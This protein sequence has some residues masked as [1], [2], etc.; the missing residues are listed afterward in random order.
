MGIILACIYMFV[1][2]NI[3]SYKMFKTNINPIFVFSSIWIA[4]LFMH[5]LYYGSNVMVYIIIFI[6]SFLFLLGLLFGY[7]FKIKPGIKIY[8]LQNHRIFNYEFILKL[9][10]LLSIVKCFSVMRTIRNILEIAGNFYIFLTNTTYIRNIY[11]S[12][13]D[14]PS[15][16]ISIINNLFGYTSMLGILL[17][18]VYSA[19]NFMNKKKRVLICL[20]LYWF[21]MSIIEAYFTMSKLVFFVNVFVFM[22]IYINI[23]TNL[24]IIKIKQLAKI[25]LIIAL[26]LFPFSMLIAIQRN[27][28]Y[29]EGSVLSLIRVTFDKTINYFVG[30]LE[31]FATLLINRFDEFSFGSRTFRPVVKWLIAFELLPSQLLPP[32]FDNPVMLKNGGFINVYTLFGFMYKDF[33][34]LG[35][36]VIPFLLGNIMGVIF[37]YKSNSLTSLI[38]RAFSF[39]VI[40]F[41]FY[42]FLAQETF[43]LL[44]PF[45]VFII[46]KLLMIVPQKSRKYKQI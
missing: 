27:Y 22:F 6:A 39:L 24:G 3:I 32:F 2:F 26:I 14:I 7:A 28:T 23:K 10:I 11:L 4:T 31:G 21:F 36:S 34:V 1:L 18:A 37:A 13:S 5:Y 41:S 38:L 9:I 43:Y 46:E 44:F 35:Y 17:L 40:I 42:N 8:D 25:T 20:I 30:P 16:G 19:G 12:R 33:G 45:F 29:E 15:L